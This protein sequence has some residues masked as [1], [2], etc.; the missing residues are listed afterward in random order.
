MQRRDAS[1]DCLT[2]GLHLER[3]ERRVLLSSPLG[4]QQ[5][6]RADAGGAE[7]LLRM[8]LAGLPDTD[9]PTANPGPDATALPT[10][11]DGRRLTPR[12]D[13][14]ADDYHAAFEVEGL[15]RDGHPDA[16]G[17]GVPGVQNV[18]DSYSY[19]WTATLRSS[20]DEA[21]SALA[22]D[23]DGNVYLAGWYENLVDFD[24]SPD[25]DTHVCN[26]G[27]DI[28]VTRL[29]AD[30]SYGWTWT[31]VSGRVS[32]WETRVTRSSWRPMAA[33]DLPDSS[34]TSPGVPLTPAQTSDAYPSVGIT[35]TPPLWAGN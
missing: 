34:A 25:V 28:F 1:R 17:A 3:L 29:N 13:S 33:S 8:G 5:T 27:R 7:S 10:S 30:G 20:G 15:K 32:F 22:V 18:L 6:I 21:V 35:L 2:A 26:G 9:L 16:A 23:E 4:L 24:P 19:A 12:A 14:L 11:L 31:A